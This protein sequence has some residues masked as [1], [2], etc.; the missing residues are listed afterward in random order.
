MFFSTGKSDDPELSYAP[1]IVL[2]DGEIYLLGIELEE[3]A[4]NIA[5]L[6]NG[7]LLCQRVIPIKPAK[8]LLGLKQLRRRSA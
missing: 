1:Y 2:K 6:L 8:A 4:Q 5:H 3:E 7:S